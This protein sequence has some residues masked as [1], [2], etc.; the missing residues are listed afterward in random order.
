[1]ALAVAAGLLLHARPSWAPYHEVVIQQV[2]FGTEDEPNAQY[3]ELRTLFIAQV[4]VENQRIMTNGADGSDAPDFGA[5]SA[6]IVIPD[7][8]PGVSMLVATPEAE[9][10]FGITADQRVEGRLVFPDGRVCFGD[11]TFNPGRPVD[12]VAYGDYT[13]SNDPFGAP[14]VAPQLGMALVRI[15]ETDDNAND[16]QLGAPRP[17]NN[18]GQVRGL[19]PE[20]PGDCNE[21]EQVTI[22]EVVTSVN[23]SGDR[24][25]LELCPAAD[26]NADGTVAVDDLVASTGAALRGCPLGPLGTRRFSL[27]P[28]SSCLGI[29]GFIDFDFEGFEGFVDFEA[30]SPDPLTGLARVDIV[31]ASPYLELGVN[32]L[33]NIFAL[34]LRPARE[35]FPI[36]GAGVIDC[37]GGSNL[38]VAVTQDHN[39]GEVGVDI[40]EAQCLAV[41]GTLDTTVSEGPPP[42]DHTGICNGPFEPGQPPGDS[43]P[44]ALVIA[45]NPDTGQ[46]GFPMELTMEEALPCGDEGLSGQIIPFAFTSA[47]VQGTVRDANNLEDNE[48]SETFTGENFDCRDWVEDG[49]GTLLLIAPLLDVDI[50]I[51]VRDLLNVFYLDDAGEGLCGLSF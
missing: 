32:A 4:F 9:A 19:P 14:A 15:H 23:V 48:V 51:A 18:A 39:I 36:I 31:D 41:G 33:G 12:C 10:L 27:D 20:C 40:T 43:G 6:D 17:R 42:V 47:T 44:G 30:G 46:G 16:F 29:R 34:C 13:G 11:D 25:D 26:A 21:D 24:I 1:L 8:R 37:N 49:P 2:F 22:D 28:T 7:G 3:V 50:G 5:F 38:G 45:P 35:L